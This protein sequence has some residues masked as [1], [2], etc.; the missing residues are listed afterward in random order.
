MSEEHEARLIGKK[1]VEQGAHEV[2]GGDLAYPFQQYGML[3]AE[4]V[5]ERGCQ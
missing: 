1:D 4:C 3:E 5:C 2:I